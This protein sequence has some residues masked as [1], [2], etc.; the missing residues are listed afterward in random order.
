MGRICFYQERRSNFVGCVS[1]IPR[2]LARMSLSR[3]LGK[4]ALSLTCLLIIALSGCGRPESRVQAG[5]RDGILHVGNGIE[6][7]GLDPHTN[8]GSPE[9]RI[10]STLFEGLVDRDDTGTGSVPGVA[11]SWEISPSSVLR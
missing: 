11:E 9:S 5:I 1:A 7:Q 4:I 10:I 3:I 6:P 8:T 2:H